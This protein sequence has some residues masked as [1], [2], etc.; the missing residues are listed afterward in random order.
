[1]VIEGISTTLELAVGLGVG[2]YYAIPYLVS[3]FSLNSNRERLKE[4][5]GGLSQPPDIPLD[6]TALEFLVLANFNHSNQITSPDEPNVYDRT[7][8]GLYQHLVSLYNRT[9]LKSQV[10]L[11]ESREDM[12]H[13]YEKRGAYW[14]N[15]DLGIDVKVDGKWT[16]YSSY[17]HMPKFESFEQ[18]REYAQSLKNTRF[19]EEHRRQLRT[20][21]VKRYMIL[22]HKMPI[23]IPTPR[24]LLG[25]VLTR[26][27][28]S[29]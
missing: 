14:S 25:G 26:M 29:L 28:K 3:T 27:I 5:I 7:T 12:K 18:V 17:W 22:H 13:L 9:D 16:P 19:D 20:T 21:P 4:F 24:F 8:F 1:M 11:H 23:P 6:A 2:T 15:I 10:R